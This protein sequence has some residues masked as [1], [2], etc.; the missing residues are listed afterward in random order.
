MSHWPTMECGHRDGCSVVSSRCI[1][2]DVCLAKAL[3]PW[4]VLRRKPR[5][6]G[7]RARSRGQLLAKTSQGLWPSRVCVLP[8]LHE[9]PGEGPG[10]A[11]PGGS[12]RV[13]QRALADRW[14]ASLGDSVVGAGSAHVA[15]DGSTHVGQAATGQHS[16]QKC[17]LSP[18]AAAGG[19]MFVSS[20]SQNCGTYS[21][22]L[23]P[24]FTENQTIRDTV[25][26]MHTRALL[27]QGLT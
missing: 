24:Q 25:L 22:F 1:S 26:W 20:A 7:P 6:E 23:M 10:L 3:S 15:T 5:P 17:L 2:P 11:D 27:P 16:Y 4:L 9:L 19:P 18:R 21:S 14:A 12:L 13:T 8:K